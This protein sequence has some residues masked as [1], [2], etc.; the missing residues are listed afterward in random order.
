MKDNIIKSLGRIF[1]PNIC[2]ICGTVIHPD[3]RICRACLN[4]VKIIK[5]PKC[6]KCGKQLETDE[7]LYCKDCDGM[8]HIFDRGICIFE[9]TEELKKSLYGFKYGNKRCFR[10]FFGY[11][12]AKKYRKLLKEWKVEWIVPVPMY[13]KKQQKRGYNQ[14]EEFGQA[15]AEYTG[16]KPDDK[17]L[18]RV[19]DTKPQ[20]G[21]SK[22]ERHQNLQKAFGV[23]IERVK[24]MK[25]VLL[26]D[27]IYTTGSTMDACAKVLKAAGVKKV[28]FMCVAGGKD[29]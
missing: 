22:E 8:N 10:D 23:D 9:Y 5:E 13:H 19:R 21:L 15:L 29:K 7:K 2:P 20:K 27:D 26:V 11:A 1:F 24:G 3:E 28:Y 16:I 6:Q 4:K 17:C 14:A 25:S 18:I 12:G